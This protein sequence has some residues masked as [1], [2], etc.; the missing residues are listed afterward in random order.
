MLS[1]D[2]HIVVFALAGS[3]APAEERLLVSDDL[4]VSAIVLWE[5]SKLFQLGRIRHDPGSAV[6]VAFLDQCQILPLNLQTA[7][8]SSKLDFRSDPADEIIAATSVVF[9]APLVTRDEQIRSSQVAL[10]ALPS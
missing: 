5:L 4:G 7:I 8:L 9:N 3:L 2:T 10:L 1:L 6:V